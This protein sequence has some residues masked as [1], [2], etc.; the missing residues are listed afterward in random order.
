[1][2]DGNPA[3]EVSTEARTL[4]AAALA[5]GGGARYIRVRVGHG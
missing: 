3:I 1:M 2:T 4:L 5:E